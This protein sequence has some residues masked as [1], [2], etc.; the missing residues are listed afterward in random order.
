MFYNFNVNSVPT[1]PEKND[2]SVLQN[3][4]ENSN[5]NYLWRITQFE[6]VSHLVCYHVTQNW[7][8]VI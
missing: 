8:Q 2:Y 7:M 5:L 4:S 6:I 1:V 3:H